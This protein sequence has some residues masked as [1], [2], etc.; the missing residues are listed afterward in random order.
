MKIYKGHIAMCPYYFDIQKIL[1]KTE[2]LNNRA[3]DRI[4][5]YL[6][7]VL[8]IKCSNA[9]QILAKLKFA[10]GAEGARTPDLMH[11]MHAL[12][13]LSYSPKGNTNNY[14]KIGEFLLVGHNDRCAYIKIKILIRDNHGCPLRLFFK[15][16]GLPA[17]AR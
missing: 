9:L 1:K 14:A 11:A 13:Q 8:M 7:N 16:I 17:E 4:V 2:H 10:G 3:I 5:T 15:K 12:S 6:I